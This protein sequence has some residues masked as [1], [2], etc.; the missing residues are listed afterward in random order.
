VPFNFRHTPHGLAAAIMSC[1]AGIGVRNGCFCAHPYMKALMGLD[2]SVEDEMVEYL[3]MDDR[4]QL[5]GMI[6]CSFG[7]YNTREELDRLFEIIRKI[8]RKEY[9]GKYRLSRSTG[10]FFAE[11]YRPNLDRYFAF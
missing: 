8:D 11:G 1:E 4:S 6:R 2:D 3:N 9:R 10:F 5:P 7:F